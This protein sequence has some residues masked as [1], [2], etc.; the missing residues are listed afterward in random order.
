[1]KWKESSSDAT[2]RWLRK[3]S[4]RSIE[5]LARNNGAVLRIRRSFVENG[6]GLEPVLGRRFYGSEAVETEVK[7]WC[8]QSAVGL[9]SGG[10]W[11]ERM[12]N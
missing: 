4:D 5:T 12:G 3:P 8:M 11:I 9:K 10:D 7:G 1:V 2:K 6:G